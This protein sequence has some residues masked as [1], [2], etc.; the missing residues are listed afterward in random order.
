[1]P[2]L[3]FGS[4]LSRPDDDLLFLRGK[5]RQKRAQGGFATLE[6]PL[7]FLFCFLRSSCS[8][9]GLNR[10]TGVV[11]SA[12]RLFQ[13]VI[14]SPYRLNTWGAPEDISAVY[15]HRWGTQ[16]IGLEPNGY[17]TRTQL[18]EYR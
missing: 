2:V 17:T 16:S 9:S 12:L 8:L 13:D 7:M 10:A 11:S 14:G 6:N 18:P 15:P 3:H 4:G 1:M 5:R